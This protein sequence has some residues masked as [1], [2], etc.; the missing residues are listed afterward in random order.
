MPGEIILGLGIT[1]LLENSMVSF[2][3]DGRG[4]RLRYLEGFRDRS[5]EQ[6][7]STGIDP[8]RKRF[9]LC[10]CLGTVGRID[11]T[12]RQKYERLNKDGFS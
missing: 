7:P 12:R 6:T 9:E 1:S 11:E 5:I 3:L 4:D 2:F 8:N 10:R